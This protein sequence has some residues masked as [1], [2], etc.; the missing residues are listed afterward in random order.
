[1]SR[2]FAAGVLANRAHGERSSGPGSMLLGVAVLL[3]A[4]L[5]AARAVG[6]VT[7][8]DNSNNSGYTVP[9]VAANL[10][11]PTNG[12]SLSATP[13][14]P[15]G[16]GEG[17]NTT[18][19]S[20]LT[21]GS[22]GT[23]GS[24]DS[25]TLEVNIGNTLIYS[26][27]TA[28]APKGYTI[29]NVDSFSGWQDSGRVDQD[30]TVLYSTVTDSSNFI[31]LATVAFPAGSTNGDNS[32][33]VDLATTGLTGVAAIKFV[34]NNQQN[35]YV[36]FKELSVAGSAAGA[37]SSIWTGAVDTT[38]ANSGNWTGGVPGATTGTTNTDSAVFN[39]YNA[40]NPVPVVDAGRNLQ[41]IGFGN[42]TGALTASLNL[43]TTTGNA[44]LLTSGGT[45]Q[46]GSAVNL[47][48]NVNA[49]LVL[50][51]T[52]GTYTFASNAAT[53]TA[54]LNF[55]GAITAGA[56]SGTTTLT[57]AG[58][59]SGANTISGS[60]G[61]GSAQTALNVQGGNWVLNGAN[62]Y[63]GATTL[64]GGTLQI[65]DGTS[66]SLGSTSISIG[67]GALILAAGASVGGNVPIAV[68][69]G[70]TFAAEPGSST[71]SIGA[72]GAGSGG[73]TLSVASGG[74]FSMVDGAV[75]TFNLRQQNS[76]A[77]NPALSLNGATLHFDLSSGG[78]DLLAVGAG[79][80]AVSGANNI[81]IAPVGSS[82]TPG[83]YPLISAPAGGLTG[84]FQ[85]A[86]GS[87]SQFVFA[88][89]SSYQLTLANTAKTE[90]VTV[91]AASF[92]N[93]ITDTFTG[94]A[95]ASYASHTPD[96]NL[97][98]GNY[99][100]QADNSTSISTLVGGG[101]G[102]LGPDIGVALPIGSTGSYQKPTTLT[103]SAGLESGTTANGGD[104]WR[105]IGLGFYSSLSSASGQN[106]YFNFA[107]LVLGPDGTLYLVP[108]KSGNPKA[109]PVETVPWSGV[110]G[111]DFS[112]STMYTLTYTINTTTG[113]ISG[114]SLSGSNADF[115]PID[116]DP[117]GI[118]T[119]A[120][121]AFA[122]FTDSSNG[123]GTAGEF[124]NFSLIGQSAASA[125]MV[126][127]YGAA[128]NNWA[129][130]GNWSGTVPGSTTGT[131]NG[132][133]ATF[134]Q[135]TAGSPLTI[136]AGR[137]LMNI[138]FDTAAVSSN[139][140]GTT[141]GPAL[142]LTAGG[143]IQTTATV[144]NPQTINAPLVLEGNYTITSGATTGTATL[145]FG[146]GITPGAASG[147][148]TLTL[149]GANTGANT[150][151]G[152][153]A[154]NSA[155]KL[156]ISKSDGG[157]WRLTGANT[158]TGGI[159]VGAEVRGGR[160]ATNGTPAIG[161]G[162]AISGS[163]TLELAGSVSQLS[164]AVNIANNSSATTGLLVSSSTAQKVG[165][166]LGTGN[167]VVNTGASLTAY[168]F[169]QNSLTIAGTG[170]VT[171][172]PSGSGSTATPAA[173]NNTN[174]SSSLNS[175]SIA[176]TTDAWTG[177]L[178]IGNNALVIPYG[179]GT[180]P[181]TALV[182][183]VDQPC[184]APAAWSGTATGITNGLAAAAGNSSAPL[185]ISLRDFRAGCQNGDP[186]RRW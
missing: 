168:Q 109:A 164:Q 117:N 123:F 184:P 181:Y 134:N 67:G 112:T 137:N 173:P 126:W 75:G 60:I 95:G 37:T 5:C 18:T 174:F 118:F 77:G 29:T 51:G 8:T 160:P 129:D 64:S 159:G 41:N 148:T 167:T 150:I 133:T 138:T 66:G 130:A 155:G 17:T 103:I 186:R 135:A 87:A 53:T 69:S 147:T 163:G 16:S 78:A 56:T 99:A 182:N 12:T 166:I 35:G 98:G 139:T 47:P 91:A 55:G 80:A 62:T 144:A 110:G 83:T 131:T 154:D 7:E 34:F 86:G 102:A 39:S 125:G 54:T 162:A 48:Q 119:D 141:T 111:A 3:S 49:P 28:S 120:N 40:T 151:S 1:M 52:N 21:D 161:G 25:T 122:G 185:N 76:F 81:V 157:T 57:L 32:S 50:E 74:N 36:G 71:L 31:M 72:T 10:L 100:F 30:Y 97:P 152:V 124:S 158:F 38:W 4:S 89:S 19:W 107:G 84:T 22:F 104:P 106:G 170:K 94:S 24:L 9:S 113:A 45:I 15:P 116:S 142:L 96:V 146:G 143:T 82:L 108:P 20:I 172:S 92:T 85:F 13:P 178:D 114:V 46:T 165:T 14:A 59:N 153:L 128:T 42:T 26:L 127:T 65:S 2:D 90:T 105:G 79:M 6:Q 180:D 140:I 11:S 136:D 27:D 58:T 183:M 43:G 73:A 23:V 145:T 115:S 179:A 177:T 175:L 101:A 121:T 68:T 33:S 149:N 171:L 88:G 61:N 63:T 132:D 44:L 176:G 93:I 169:R 156:A 70:G